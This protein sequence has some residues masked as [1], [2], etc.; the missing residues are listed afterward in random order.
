VSVWFAEYYKNKA[1][2]KKV[3]SKKYPYSL[4]LFYSSITDRI[5]L[6]PNEDEYIL[7]GMSSYGK[8]SSV[9]A[10]M[11]NQLNYRNNHRGCRDLYLGINEFDIAATAQSVLEEELKYIFNKA[12]SITQVAQVCYGG[13]VAL[14]CSANSKLISQVEDLWIFPNPGDAGSA[15]GA[16]ALINRNSISFNDCYLGH[17]IDRPY[18]VK[19]A[20]NELLM[21]GVVGVANGKAEFGPRA[22][23]NRSLFADPRNPTMKNK[24]NSIKQRQEF[25]PFAPI[26]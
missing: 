17:N 19:K 7:M 24:I 3:W 26:V 22:L 10:E 23:G 25:R 15:V 1:Q 20:I 4:G 2:Y 9:Y 6:K 16:A 13:G 14:N 18:P 11:K 21:S 5:G 8:I 12:I